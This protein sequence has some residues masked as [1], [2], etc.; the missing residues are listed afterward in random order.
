MHNKR[1]E[2]LHQVQ[3]LLQH[4]PHKEN[5]ALKLNQ[6]LSNHLST[7]LMT[8]VHSDEIETVKQLIRCGVDVNNHYSHSGQPSP[9]IIALKNNYSDIVNILIE[10]NANL[11]LALFQVVK[12][13]FGIDIQ[14]R[15]EI[16][17]FLLKKG[18]RPNAWMFT[19]NILCTMTCGLMDE[20]IVARLL[21]AGANVN[22]QNVDLSTPLHNAIKLGQTVLSYPDIDVLRLLLYAGAHINVTTSFG[23]TALQLY[24]S[25]YVNIQ[26]DIFMLLLAAGDTLSP[27]NL[28]QNFQNIPNEVL[29]FLNPERKEK[30]TLKSQCKETIRVQLLK[31]NTVNLFLKVPK[32]PL[33]LPIKKYLLHYQELGI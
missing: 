32:L 19:N 6:F 14:L 13:H 11:D 4:H 16:V 10:A 25:N 17:D 29:K 20:K 12:F 31:K 3:C 18:A 24:I 1:M 27:H 21:K 23:C 5:F 26:T 8:A 22:A 28:V 30:I 7:D 2:L 15:Y 33:P 9:L